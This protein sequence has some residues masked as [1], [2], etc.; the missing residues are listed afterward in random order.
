RCLKPGSAAA[1]AEGTC[2][3]GCDSY[4]AAGRSLHD[5]VVEAALKALWVNQSQLGPI[6]PMLR[7]WT[8]D[9]AVGPDVTIPYHPAA[10]RFYKERGVWRPELD[11][12]QQKLLSVAP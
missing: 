5:P 11:Q 10:V 2:F 9:R 6:H 7:E 1:I 8:R 12:L 4:L 3:T